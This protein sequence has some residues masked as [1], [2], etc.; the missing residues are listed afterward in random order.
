ML[1]EN[2]VGQLSNETETIS[3]I[4]DIEGNVWY[5]DTIKVSHQMLRNEANITKQKALSF[6]TNKNNI[7]LSHSN[8]FHRGEAKDQ[9]QEL[10]KWA[11][12]FAKKIWKVNSIKWI[13]DPFDLA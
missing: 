8:D 7:V 1:Q 5:E 12:N 3:G 13:T 11:E 4:I 10:T 9:I 2:M 6:T